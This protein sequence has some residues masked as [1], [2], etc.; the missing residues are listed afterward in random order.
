MENRVKSAVFKRKTKL[1]TG[2][3]SGGR[4][5]EIMFRSQLMT[6][7]QKKPI[8]KKRAGGVAQGIGPGYK[9]L[10]RINKQTNKQIINQQGLWL[11]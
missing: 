4:D 11:K 10:Y 3:Y 2:S 6:L 1:G 7:S 9:P 5:Q 8:T